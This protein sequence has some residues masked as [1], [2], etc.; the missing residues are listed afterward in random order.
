MFRIWF[1]ENNTG[2]LTDLDDQQPLDGVQKCQN[3]VFYTSLYTHII[4][5]LIIVPLHEIKWDNITVDVV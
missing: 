4:K 3:C 1:R 5:L 2:N